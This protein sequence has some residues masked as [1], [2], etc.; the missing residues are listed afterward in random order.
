M[1]QHV[2]KKKI[3]FLSQRKTCSEKSD[4]KTARSKVTTHRNMCL[5]WSESQG[6]FCCSVISFEVQWSVVSACACVDSRM[7]PGCD[8]KWGEERTSRRGPCEDIYLF[9]SVRRLLE[10][11]LQSIYMDFP[12]K[13]KKPLE[14]D[15]RGA[16]VCVYGRWFIGFLNST[17]STQSPIGFNISL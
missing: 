17:S 4:K 15:S 2:V 11:E 8:F 10:T 6:T 7:R 5:D 1:L 16:C 9:C 3:G 12:W 13:R 14:T